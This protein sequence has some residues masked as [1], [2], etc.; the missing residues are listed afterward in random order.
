MDASEQ[1]ISPAIDEVTGQCTNGWVCE[2]RWPAIQNMIKFRTS[3]RNSNVTAWWDNHGNQI[4]FCRGTRGFVAFNNE[5]Y[6]MDVSLF[7][8]LASGVYCDVITGDVVDNK[9]TGTQVTVDENGE[10]RIQIAAN[11]GVLAIHIGV[12]IQN[13]RICSPTLEHATR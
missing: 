1:L 8:C 12:I 3:V 10:A 9:C 4:S 11:V 2:H 7:T 6:D 5:N 13:N